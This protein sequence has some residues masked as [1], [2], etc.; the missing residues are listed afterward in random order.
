MFLSC[1]V[2]AR[3]HLEQWPVHFHPQFSLQEELRPCR[4]PKRMTTTW[5]VI[6][7]GSGYFPQEAEELGGSVSW[8]SRGPAERLPGASRHGE[9]QDG[10][11]APCLD[12][13]G[14]ERGR[15]TRRA[16]SLLQGWV[17]KG[18]GSESRYQGHWQG[19]DKRCQGTAS[20]MEV[21]KSKGYLLSLNS[22]PE[23]VLS[24]LHHNHVC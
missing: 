23:A 18:S 10:C 3:K 14:R 12:L 5:W 24:T 1:P 17:V 8:P 4:E 21:V 22:E 11:L 15:E 9:R 16:C 19:Q 20:G 6:P 7:A 13:V 2:L